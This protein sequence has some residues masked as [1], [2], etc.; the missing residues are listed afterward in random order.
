LRFVE[1]RFVEL[2]IVEMYLSKWLCRVVAYSHL[3]HL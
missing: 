3:L 1:L 2:P